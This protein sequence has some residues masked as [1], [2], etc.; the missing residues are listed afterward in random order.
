M[1]TFGEKWSSAITWYL[2]D[3]GQFMSPERVHE[4]LFKNSN[5]RFLKPSQP[6]VRRYNKIRSLVQKA[7]MTKRLLQKEKRLRKR[8]AEKGL[9]YDFPGFVSLALF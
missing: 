5:R 7:K 8:L 9:N 1:S 3:T 4:N 2:Y 6:A